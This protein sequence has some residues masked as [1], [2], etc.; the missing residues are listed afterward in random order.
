MVHIIHVKVFSDILHFWCKKDSKNGEVEPPAASSSEDVPKPEIKAEAEPAEKKP[1]LTP[2]TLG[3]YEPNTPVG[4]RL[5]VCVCEH[6][7]AFIQRSL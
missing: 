2:L 6:L 5:W 1:E 3:P 4:K 7:D